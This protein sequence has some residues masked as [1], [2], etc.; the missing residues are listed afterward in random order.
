M[1]QFPGYKIRACESIDLGFGC[2]TWSV[3]HTPLPIYISGKSRLLPEIH[4][5][6]K[7]SEADLKEH[8]T[9]FIKNASA[10]NP[11][12]TV[13][14]FVQDHHIVEGKAHGP[15]DKVWWTIL[16]IVLSKPNQV[17]VTNDG[18]EFHQLNDVKTTA[19]VHT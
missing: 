1:L 14:I 19:K 7:L 16:S 5:S 13:N 18:V 8:V 17:L 11:L 12:H 10:K 9:E 6:S 15:S 3:K 2:P 4:L